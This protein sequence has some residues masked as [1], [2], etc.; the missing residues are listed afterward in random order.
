MV[1]IQQHPVMAATGL[2]SSWQSSSNLNGCASSRWGQELFQRLNSWP[3][4]SPSPSPSPPPLPSV[5]LL[6][7]LS[8][9]IGYGSFGVVW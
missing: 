7:D 2:Y 1:T 3:L 8:H 6:V 4:S 5:P 9:P